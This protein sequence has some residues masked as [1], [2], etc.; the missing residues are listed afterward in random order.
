[1]RTL[2]PTVRTLAVLLAGAVAVHLP[3][4]PAHLLLVVL[5]GAAGL[6]PLLARRG[7]TLARALAAVRP[8]ATTVWRAPEVRDLTV[9]PAPGAPGTT[10]ARAPARRVRAIA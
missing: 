10:L 3:V 9:P 5:V 1:M 8:R 4:S 2:A 7:G 6:L